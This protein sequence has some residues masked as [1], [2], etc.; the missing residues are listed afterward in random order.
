MQVRGRFRF[1][2]PFFK[3]I[4]LIDFR[5]AV[6]LHVHESFLSVVVFHLVG[7]IVLPTNAASQVIGALTTSLC[8]RI[9]VLGDLSE[10]CVGV[11]FCF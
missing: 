1:Q 2:G 10:I 7:G 6:F 3:L 9:H 5:S 8:C 11:I 4:G